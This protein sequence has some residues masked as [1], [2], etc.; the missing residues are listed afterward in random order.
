[1]GNYQL[2]MISNKHQCKMVNDQ[3][4][5]INERSIIYIGKISFK[6]IFNDHWTLT[7]EH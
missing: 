6:K 3:L 1:M 2:A 4:A 7:I 5:I